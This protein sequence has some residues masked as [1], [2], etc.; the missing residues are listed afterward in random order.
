M[1]DI[2]T[3]TIEKYKKIANFIFHYLIFFIA[4]IVAFF[5]FQNI[6]SQSS[7]INIFQTNTNILTK[8]NTLI[9][10]FNKFFN[11]NTNN[12][13]ITIYILQ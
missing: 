10:E 7:A 4:T 6:I 8:K 5:I 11:Q 12:N 1:N 3:K 9:A 13:N 2:Q